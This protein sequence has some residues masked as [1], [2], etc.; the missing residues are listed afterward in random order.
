MLKEEKVILIAGLG[1]PG[2]QYAETRHNIGFMI[3]DKLANRLGVEFSKMQSN[4]MVTKAR[5][6]DHRLILAKPRT[7]M[8]NSG[9]AVSALARYY[10]VL[11]ENILIIYDDVDLDFE[12]IRLRPDGSSSG[13]KGMDSVIKSLGTDKIPRLRVGIGRPPGKMPT[14]NYVLRPFSPEEKTVLPFIIDRAVEAVLEFIEYDI[15]SAM[16]KFNQKSV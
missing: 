6:L 14:P 10:K 8:N 9:Q 13:Q 7:F 4:A 1:N 12:I 16:N 15:N 11:E 5:Y 2:K 3:V